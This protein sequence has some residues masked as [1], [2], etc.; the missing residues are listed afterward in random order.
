[1]HHTNYVT[2]HLILKGVFKGSEH[3]Q[4]VHLC[5][6]FVVLNVQIVQEGAFVCQ[7]AYGGTQNSSWQAQLALWK[8]SHKISFQVLKG[9][10]LYDYNILVRFLT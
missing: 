10:S 1:M 3:D 8:L 9:V 5:F 6:Q 4:S 7:A 2:I